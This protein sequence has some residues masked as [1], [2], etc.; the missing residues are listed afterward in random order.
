M[1]D[2]IQSAVVV[3][4]SLC[5]RDYRMGSEQS[6][7]ESAGSDTDTLDSERQSLLST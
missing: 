5:L 7:P 3:I 2:T 6:R 4:A 1:R